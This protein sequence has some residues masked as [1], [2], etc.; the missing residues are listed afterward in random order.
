MPDKTVAYATP[1]TFTLRG[2]SCGVAAD[3]EVNADGSVT[4]SLYPALND[5]EGK[6]YYTYDQKTELIPTDELLYTAP[7]TLTATA[8]VR[9]IMVE[10]EKVAGPLFVLPVIVKLIEVPEKPVQPDKPENCL[11][12]TSPSPRD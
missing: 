3:T 5:A 11:L 2:I 4:V 6:I 10:T 8:A 12:Y 7:F 1:A 9:A